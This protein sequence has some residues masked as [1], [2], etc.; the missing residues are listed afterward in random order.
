MTEKPR[1]FLVTGKP[2]R[3][4]LAYLHAENHNKIV[5]GVFCRFDYVED[6]KEYFPGSEVF[7]DPKNMND[8]QDFF[9][10]EKLCFEEFE[11][12]IKSKYFANMMIISERCSPVP[13]GIINSIEY[14]REAYSCALESLKR[15]RPTHVLFSN[16]PH[17]LYSYAVYAACRLRG[18][19]TIVIRT[20]GGYF[21]HIIIATGT[22][23]PP[24][25]TLEQGAPSEISVSKYSEAA[26]EKIKRGSIPDYMIKQGYMKTRWGFAVEFFSALSRADMKLFKSSI[27][28]MHGFVCGSSM[29]KMRKKYRLLEGDLSKLSKERYIFF[30]LHYQPEQT[31]MPYANTFAAQ[32]LVLKELIEAVQGELDI[33]V[34]EHPSMLLKSRNDYHSYRTEFMA[35]LINKNDNVYLAPVMMNSHKLILNA[36]AVITLTGTAGYE[37]LA[38][39]IPVLVFGSAMFSNS[40]MVYRCKDSFD[41]EKSLSSSSRLSGPKGA[42]VLKRLIFALE[43]ISIEIPEYIL[44]MYGSSDFVKIARCYA[45]SRIMNRIESG[46]GLL[47]PSSSE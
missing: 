3:K 33:V 6:V 40:E 9:L 21:R 19:E 43:Q 16:F 44:D 10:K 22:M 5:K 23:E 27:K 15:I 32:G 34:K 24:K 14:V 11:E 1:I 36:K 8:L 31:S 7:V 26:I 42:G 2:G 12:L 17:T 25:L 47:R 4:E 30:P 29:Q 28:K 20:V 46:D 18:I 39:D 37:A 13:T 41:V 35:D 38:N 45:A